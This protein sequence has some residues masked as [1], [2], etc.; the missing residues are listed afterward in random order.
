VTQLRR[1]VLLLLLGVGAL[2]LGVIVLFGS[3]DWSVDALAA[4]LLVGG[5]AIIVVALPTSNGK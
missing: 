3:R 5:L 2:V 1:Q 4:G